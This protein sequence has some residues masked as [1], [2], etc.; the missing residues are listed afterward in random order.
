MQAPRNSPGTEPWPV[1]QHSG[2]LLSAVPLFLSSGRW[3]TPLPQ[4]LCPPCCSLLLPAAF[5]FM[6]EDSLCGA[7]PH[8]CPGGSC[9]AWETSDTR[10]TRLGDL[11]CWK[12]LQKCSGWFPTEAL[13]ER[14]NTSK[15]VSLSCHCSEQTAPK[16]LF[17][18]Q[19]GGEL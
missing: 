6:E 11:Q 1:W 15:G 16:H 5:C 2:H 4:I 13:C 8:V 3:A 10:V 19:Y 18:G 9:S 7:E 17:Q 14:A 12:V